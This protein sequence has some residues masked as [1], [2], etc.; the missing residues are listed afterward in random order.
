MNILQQLIRNHFGEHTI[1]AVQRPY[2]DFTGSIEGGLLLT[3]M[4]YWHDRSSICKDGWFFKT[5]AEWEAE[6]GL[7]RKTINTLISKWKEAGFLETDLRKS[8]KGTPITHYRFLMDEFLE[9]FSNF[10]KKSSEVLKTLDLSQ[11]TKGNVLRDKRECPLGQKG[12]SQG[13][14]L[15]IYTKTTSET[16]SK[17][18]SDPERVREEKEFFEE[19]EIVESELI[20][21]IEEERTEAEIDR[22]Y[23]PA[24]KEHPRLRSQNLGLDEISQQAQPGLPTIVSPKPIFS[25]ENARDRQ[26]RSKGINPVDYDLFRGK[27]LGFV[28]AVSISGYG[29]DRDVQYAWQNLYHAE[30]WVPDDD[31][32]A[33]LDF[34]IADGMAR[35]VAGGNVPLTGICGGAKWLSDRRWER[36]LA[37]KARQES[38]GILGLARKVVKSKEQLKMEGFAKQDAAIAEFRK[39]RQ[40]MKEKLLEGSHA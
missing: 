6:L 22:Y 39:M 32:W 24:R 26:L 16:S 12:M 31:F 28:E 10:A 14:N 18:S 23:S 25:A 4:I 11:G 35:F 7:K 40:E 1:L 3:Q 38:L 29:S 8:P 34:E 13:T 17:T 5:F 2:I 27:Y 9:V 20:E 37:R 30:G 33:G 15:P 21:T 36:A 19:G